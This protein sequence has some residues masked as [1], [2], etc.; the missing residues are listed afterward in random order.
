MHDGKR[1]ELKQHGALL[2]LA[3]LIERVN[4]VIGLHPE[5]NGGRGRTNLKEADLDTRIFRRDLK[6]LWLYFFKEL[7]G[8]ALP[9]LDDNAGPVHAKFPQ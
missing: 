7:P 5:K 9:D 1:T 2:Q 6:C 4:P 3:W 8:R